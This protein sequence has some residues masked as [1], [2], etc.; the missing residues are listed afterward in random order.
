MK[1]ILI[2]IVLW[3][4]GA[5]AQER[6]HSV[7]W[8]QRASLFELLPVG[9]RDIVFVGNSITNGG[10]W[11]ELS[12]NKRLKNRG[13]SGDISAGV[14][15]RLE[16][17]T[18][19]RPAKIFLMIGVNDISR[20]ISCETISSNI[21]KIVLK[22]KADSP[23]TDIYLQSVL[24]VNRDMQQFPEHMKPGMIEELN[25]RIA[26]LAVRHGTV[27]IDLY[28]EFVEA[29]TDKLAPEFTNDGLHLMGEGYIRWMELIEPYIRK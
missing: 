6:K 12:G 4:W 21:E 23:R 14:Y 9:P 22:I 28:P 26:E 25:R 13:I 19:G 16:S 2:L 10:E 15:D 24:P 1:K 5:S 8:E 18:R 11:S 27:W 7:F 29:G 20:N 17:V 3:S